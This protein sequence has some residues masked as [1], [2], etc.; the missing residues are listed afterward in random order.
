MRPTGILS[1]TRQSTFELAARYERDAPNSCVVVLLDEVGLAEQSP[2]LPL[3]VL[4]KVLDESKGGSVVGISNWTL[5]P[6]KMNRAAHLYR[7]APTEADLSAT[8]EGMVRSASL[9]GYLQALARAYFQVYHRQSDWQHE[10][11]W[12]LREFYS[13]IK[14]RDLRYCLTRVSINPS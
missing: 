13:L 5:D 9:K 14:V 2:H 12:G 10:D 6:A 4:H 8:A 1:F 7:P 11:F 3:K